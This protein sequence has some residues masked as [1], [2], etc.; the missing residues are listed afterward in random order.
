MYFEPV[1]SP[2]SQVIAKDIL[3]CIYVLSLFKQAE[4]CIFAD[5][6]I[7]SLNVNVLI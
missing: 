1:A 5:I 6:I 3:E 7:F 4:H 2:I